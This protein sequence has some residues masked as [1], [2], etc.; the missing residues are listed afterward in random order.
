MVD[1]AKDWVRTNAE[2][3][4]DDLALENVE[5]GDRHTWR[6]ARRAGRRGSPASLRDRCGVGVGDRVLL[7]AEG[8]TRTFEVQFACMRL[9]AILVPLN[10]RLAVPELVELAADVEPAVVILDEVWHDTGLKIAEATG[11]RHAA[12]VALPGRTVED[13]EAAIAAATPAEPRTDLS[14]RAAHPHPAHVRH[15]GTPQGRDHHRQDA[16]L[17]GAQHRGPRSAG[18]PGTK[19]LN[20]MPLFHAGGLTTIAHARS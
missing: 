4:G 19:L 2:R 1:V 9:G 10:W 17:A 8:D 12:G 15:H 20:P 6:R 16:E 18:G 13:Y 14:D 11:V 3:Y 5:T 7:L